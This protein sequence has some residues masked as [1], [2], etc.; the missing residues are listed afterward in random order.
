M[1]RFSQKP[2]DCMSTGAVTQSNQAVSSKNSSWVKKEAY[3]GRFT[4]MSKD[5]ESVPPLYIPGYKS[6]G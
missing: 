2:T 3:S 6:R 5:L 4:G 1:K